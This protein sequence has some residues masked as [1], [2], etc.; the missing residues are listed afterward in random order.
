MAV[1]TFVFQE[2]WIHSEVAG[3]KIAFFTIFDPTWIH[4]LGP[5]GLSMEF[6]KQNFNFQSMRKTGAILLPIM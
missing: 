4:I 1:K 5:K 6:L 3:M 2:N